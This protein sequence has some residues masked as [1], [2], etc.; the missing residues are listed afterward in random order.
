M[1]VIFQPIVKHY[2]LDKCEQWKIV[3]SYITGYHRNVIPLTFSQFALFYN[4]RRRNLKCFMLVVHACNA[5]VRKMLTGRKC[6]NEDGVVTFIRRNNYAV[7][8]Q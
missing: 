8:K 6:F 1:G 5:I 7:Y 3:L 4:K 2:D